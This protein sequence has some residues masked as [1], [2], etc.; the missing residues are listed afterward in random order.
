MNVGIAGAKGRG[1]RVWGWCTALALAT[2]WSC[3]DGM[4]GEN[5]QLATTTAQSTVK[6]PDGRTQDTFI[7]DEFETRARVDVLFIDDNSDSMRNAQEK[8]AERLQTF[9]GSLA[10]IDWQIG[11]TTTD[12]SDG[13]YGLKG[14]LLE[15][16]AS[17]HRILTPT[18][19]NATKLFADTIVREETWSCGDVCPSTDERPLRAT[20][21][22]IDRRATDNAG[23]FRADADL[24]VIIL[25]NEDE[26]SDGGS[27][28]DTYLQVRAAVDKAFGAQKAMTGFGLIVIPGD[29]ACLATAS[30][31]G[32][33][34][35]TLLNEFATKSGGTVG[36]ICAP[37]YGPTLTSI[38]QRVREGIKVAVLS[39]MPQPDTV[40]VTVTPEDPTLTWTLKGQTMTFVHPPKPGSKVVVQYKAK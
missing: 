30:T 2:S 14:R 15:F 21:E 38:G 18:T 16:D 39:A 9:L 8:L 5:Q 10:K 7:Y 33:H 19:A 20:I 23:F 3:T 25:S 26:A 24:V 36:S 1:R 17:H 22:A 40:K 34:Y 31:I 4:P 11:V 6:L 29:K 28:A 37:D 35:G 13:K 32:A 27:S 12:V